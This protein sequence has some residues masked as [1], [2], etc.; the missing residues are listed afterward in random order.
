MSYRTKLFA[1]LL[2]ANAGFSG[3]AGA[4]DVRLPQSRAELALSFAPLAKTVGPAVVNVFTR[5]VVQARRV[6]PL[7]DDPFFRRFFGDQFPPNP[8]TPPER[9][10]N[11]LGSGV[12]VQ[13]DGLIVTNNHVIDRADEI[14][15]VLTDRREFE[16]EIVLRDDKTDLAV[17]RIDTRGEALPHLEFRDS[18]TVEVGDLVLAIGN[19]F[20]VGQTVTSGIISALSRTARGVSD[21]NFF[22]QTDAAINPGNSG[23]ALVTLDGRLVGIN[24]AIYSR[25]GGSNGIGFAIPSNMVD[26]VVASAMSGGRVVRPWLGARGQT[27]DSDI[28]ASMRLAR[29]SGVLV[30]SIYRDGPA[31]RGGLR[32]GDVVVSVNGRDV[33]DAN[34]LRFRIGTLKVGQNAILGVIRDGQRVNVT[35]EMIP[36]PE[37]PPRDL[38]VIEGEN[39]YAGAEVANL[40]P[41]LVA[42]ISLEGEESGVVILRIKRRSPA[43]RIGLAPGDILVSLNGERIGSVAELRRLLEVPTDLWRIAIRRNGKTLLLNIRA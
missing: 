22:I 17:L 13:P 4:Q 23:G 16:A 33:P 7:F 36:A 28:A 11:S 20:G 14:T 38:T 19:P 15:V 25:G 34:S 43:D 26:T 42:E 5:R 41:A 18:D 2:I 29:P 10:Q 37:V 1:T 3:V 32:V 39:P 27:V 31:E 40:S 12:I 6:S 30:N 9:V 8:G 21:Y 24:T 35:I